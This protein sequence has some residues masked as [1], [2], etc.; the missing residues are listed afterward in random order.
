M[1]NKEIRSIVRGTYDIQKLRIQTALRLVA[2]FKVKLGQEPGKKEQTLDKWAKKLLKE[3]RRDYKLLTDGILVRKTNF[4]SQGLIDNITEFILTDAYVKLVTNEKNQFKWLEKMLEDIPLYRDYLSSVVGIGPAMGGVIISE[5]DIHKAR[6][7]SSLHMYAGLDVVIDEEDGHGEGRSKKAHHLIDVEYT[8]K[9]GEQKTRKSITYN[10]FLKS[11]LI[12]VLGPSFNK[13]GNP[14]YAP[15]YQ[16]YKHR[17]EMHSNHVEKTKGHRHA[18]AIRYSVKRFLNDLYV[19]WRTIEGL[20]VAEPYE[21]A[22]LGYK[23][24]KSA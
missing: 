11:K 17:L 23:H 6:Y 16:D 22:K 3:L 19:K 24:G 2:H 21:V 20:P 5:I 7:P 18:M 9:K 1:H 14:D 13:C 10:P 4:K 12:G 8:N 15:L